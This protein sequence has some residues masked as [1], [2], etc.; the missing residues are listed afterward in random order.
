[1]PEP[2]FMKLGI[3]IMASGP[4]STAYF[5]NLSH[6]SVCLCVYPRIV[7][8]QRL[9]KHVPAATKN[10]WRRRFLCDQK[11]VSD[12]FFTE[13]LVSVVKNVSLRG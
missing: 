12:Q 1:M 11:K 2:V 8:R 3:Y 10:F 9:G 5:I 13:L 4:F 7:A 6:Q